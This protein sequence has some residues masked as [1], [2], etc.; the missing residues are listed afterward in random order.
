MSS[1]F[2]LSNTWLPVVAFQTLND[3]DPKE[4]NASKSP[5]E[6]LS[7]NVVV[8]FNLPKFKSVLSAE[9]FGKLVAS[10]ETALTLFISVN[11]VYSLES[12]S[13]AVNK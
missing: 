13:F 11:A 1:S 7:P 8:I 9:A 4:Y 6:S 12:P 3:L 5:S 2:L 10:K